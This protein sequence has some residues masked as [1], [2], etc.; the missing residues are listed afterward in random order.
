M[1]TVAGPFSIAANLLGCGSTERLPWHFYV[2]PHIQDPMVHNIIIHFANLLA[3]MGCLLYSNT[4]YLSCYL[5]T[6]PFL[7]VW[8]YKYLVQ[9]Q[10]LLK[11]ASAETVFGTHQFDVW[12]PRFFFCQIFMGMTKCLTNISGAYLDATKQ[13]ILMYLRV[14]ICPGLPRLQFVDNLILPMST[15]IG[16][17][18]L[19]RFQRK[20]FNYSF[21]SNYST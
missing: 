4:M 13:P 16:R 15:S 10:W 5:R 19:F 21:H 17:L 1:I 3:H 14:F 9:D 6:M 18:L 2:C 7:C 8:I 11:I 12:T 20:T